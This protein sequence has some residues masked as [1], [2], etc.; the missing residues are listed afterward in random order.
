MTAY[1]DSDTHKFDL[2]GLSDVLAPLFDKAA[3]LCQKSTLLRPNPTF[4]Y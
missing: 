4:G 1:L 3:I 2:Q